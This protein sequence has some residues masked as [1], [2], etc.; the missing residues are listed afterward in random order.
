MYDIAQAEGIQLRWLRRRNKMDEGQEPAAGEKLALGGYA[1]STP[2]LAKQA[3]KEDPTIG[4]LSP[5]AIV[6]DVKDQMEA[7]QQQAAAPA[8]ASAQNNL[9]AGMVDDLKKVADVKP[10]GSS[11]A[12]AAPVTPA[13]PVVKNNPAPVKTSTGPV[14]HEVQPKETLYGIA[15]LYNVTIAQLQEWNHIE[16]FDIKIGQ[17]LLVGKM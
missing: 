11:A 16:A 17:R 10:A 14:Y 4:D 5:K 1:S 13:A 2:R 9:P 12:P 6:K 8:P 7:A 15:K 3:P